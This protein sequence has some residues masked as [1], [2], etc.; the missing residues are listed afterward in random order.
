[1]R[2]LAAILALSTTGCYSV[3]TLN[4]ASIS[5][6]ANTA[7]PPP[8]PAVQ[9]AALV[10]SQ[11]KL[12]VRVKADVNPIDMCHELLEEIDAQEKTKKK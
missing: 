2:I 3:V 4:F 6:S 12:G 7:G 8:S 5:R 10:A 9:C 11:I 1:M